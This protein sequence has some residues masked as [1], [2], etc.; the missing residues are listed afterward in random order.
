MSTA[1]LLGYHGREAQ[2][3]AAGAKRKTAFTWHRLTGRWRSARGIGEWWGN[4]PP[5][6][7][8]AWTRLDLQGNPEALVIEF[9][10][11]GA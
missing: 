4:S 7:A 2:I 9:A 10:E 6:R 11:G 1:A 8:N 5:R 3:A